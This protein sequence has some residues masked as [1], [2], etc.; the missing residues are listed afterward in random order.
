LS[1][2]AHL[3]NQHWS[4]SP[5]WSC[6]IPHFIELD[7]GKNYRNVLYLMVKTMVSCR[8]SQ[9]NQSS[10]H[11]TTDSW[12]TAR[13]A[14]SARAICEPRRSEDSGDGRDVHGIRWGTG[15]PIVLWMWVKMED[16]GDHRC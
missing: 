1:W 5:G 3:F 10:D 2:V 7:Y 14:A 12:P 13:G 6:F 9:Q 11:W 4:N 8:F 16:L 15:V